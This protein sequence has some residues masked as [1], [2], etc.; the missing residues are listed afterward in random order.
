MA[1]DGGTTPPGSVDDGD[2]LHFSSG[3]NKRSGSLA[4]GTSCFP[5]PSIA[6]S[7]GGRRCA[8]AAARVRCFVCQNLGYFSRYL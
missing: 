8:M 6:V 5:E 3:S 1:C 4:M 2:R 7:Y